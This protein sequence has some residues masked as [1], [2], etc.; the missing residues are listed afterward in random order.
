MNISYHGSYVSR[1][2]GLTRGFEFFN[3]IL[4]RLVPVNSVSLITRIDSFSSIRRYLHVRSCEY[5]F[6]NARV[7]A[8]TE[9]IF[10]FKG[11][12]E[13]RSRA[14]AAV[15]CAYTFLTRA[16]QILNCAL[17]SRLLFK[18]TKNC[19]Y[20]DITV[21]VRRPIEWIKSDAELASFLYRN[22]CSA[23]IQLITSLRSLMERR[24][25]GSS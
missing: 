25:Y 17:A 9:Y 2:I 5:E 19:P 15:P 23:F 22:L 11:E 13:L 20:T 14:I 4:D 10:P 1:G 18:D 7:K 21:D 12:H 8:K 6:S 3:S 16:K 24:L